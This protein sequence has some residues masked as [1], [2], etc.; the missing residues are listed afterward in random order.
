MKISI[1]LEAMFGM[2]WPLWKHYVSML[3]DMGFAAIYRSDHFSVD[4]PPAT[5]ALELITSLAYLADHTKKV[6]FGSLVAPLSV[7]DPVM[8]ARQAMSLNA[9]SGGRMILGVGAGWHE[10]EHSRFGYPLGDIRTRLDRFSEGLEVIS[11]L[12]RSEQPVSFQG[13]F[14]HLQDAAIFPRPKQTTRIL[15]GGKGPRRILPL[16]AR[17]AD[18]WNDNGK[19]P[20]EFSKLNAHLDQLLLAAGR[21][22]DDV[23]RTVMIP[24]LCS[25]NSQEFSRRAKKMHSVPM[26]ASFTEDYLR[27][28]LTSLGAILGTPGEVIEKMQMYANAGVDEFIIQWGTLH[29]IESL[30]TIAREILPHFTS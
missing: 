19:N 21:Q 22:P 27:G 2:G 29:D 17:Y 16:V 6:S 23:K 12:L 9:L 26:F 8:L 5:D 10:G 14:Y 28:M 30:E 18:I 13:R 1:T 4:N 24:V 20:E 25:R 11:C 15:V 7:R 3:E